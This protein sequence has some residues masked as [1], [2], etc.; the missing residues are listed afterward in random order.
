[1][2]AFRAGAPLRAA[3]QGQEPLLIPVLGSSLPEDTFTRTLGRPAFTFPYANADEANH[4]PNENIEPARF[5]ADI[6][7]GAAILD[8]LTDDSPVS[9]S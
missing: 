1:V 4:A 7:T 9:C 3:A 5:Y 2:A 8:Y 6:K